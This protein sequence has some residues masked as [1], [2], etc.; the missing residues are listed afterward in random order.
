MQQL[1]QRMHRHAAVVAGKGSLRR[2]TGA[3]WPAARRDGEP[4]TLDGRPAAG[5]R[6][7]ANVNNGE[8][9]TPNGDSCPFSRFGV[10]P[11][12]Q[13]TE[14]RL[15]TAYFGLGWNGEPYVFDELALPVI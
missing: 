1:E 15:L 5:A 11:A 14:W 4:T 10:Q 9:K 12:V 13:A 3:S 2:A 8:A 6:R 7:G